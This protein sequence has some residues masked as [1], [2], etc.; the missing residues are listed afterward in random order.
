M[1][2]LNKYIFKEMITPFMLSLFILIF[3]LATQFLIKHIDKYL[4]KGF[5]LETILKFLLY[6]I[7]WIFSLA[8]PMSIL[9]AT[10]MAFGRLSSD[11]EIT[12]L[13]GSG[14]SYWQLLKPA[15]SFGII[16]FII[17]IPFN[18][19]ILPAMNYNYKLLS[20]SVSKN[21][22]D[23]QIEEYMLNNLYQ[24]V[25]YVGDRNA[26]GSYNEIAIFDKEKENN[27]ITIFSDNG[28]FI[29]FK[30]GILLNLNNGSI[31]SYNE[32]NNEYQKTYFNNYQISVP[33]ENLDINNN[34]Q[35][36]KGQREM[37]IQLLI[38]KIN[39]TNKKINSIEELKNK[40]SNKISQLKKTEKKLH[41]KLDSL[42]KINKHGNQLFKQTELEINKNNNLISNLNSKIN[43]HNTLIPKYLKEINQ[44]YV[45]I[46]K[47]F[48]IPFA[49]LIFIILGLPLGIISKNGKFSINIAISLI[50]IV[51]YWAFINMG[52][53][54][55]DED[56]MNPALAMWLGNFTIG[57]LGIYLF[58]LSSRE[59]KSYS[60]KNLFKIVNFK[61]TITN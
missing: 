57:I 12:A 60:F 35:L 56:K 18:L 49:C 20:H 14:V 46:H 31:H 33:F 4:G 7:A 15:L 10:M 17:M 52:E 27:K 22:P 41:S 23:V 50:F 51:M 16:I 58:N 55:A 2:I 34:R 40:D 21:R 53:Y 38:Q 19:W 9:I 25:I 5:S 26:D 29:S 30:D 45:E 39:N 3:V 36:I 54:L 8:V 37:N 59:N 43:N 32:N 42:I 28:N 13:K 1:K 6:N 61:R 48:A 44:L 11:N 24:K 47:K